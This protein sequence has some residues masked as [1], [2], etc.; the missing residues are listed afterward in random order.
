MILAGRVGT[1]T[2]LL[3]CIGCLA[4][5]ACSLQRAQTAQNAQSQLVGMSKEQ[6]LGCMGPPLQK[7]VEG[8]TEVWSYASGNDRTHVTYGDGV[9]VGTRR[10]CSVNVVMTTGR[11]S[12][13]NYS[14]PSGGLLSQGE[15]C[16]F[17]VQ[18]CVVR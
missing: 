2:K 8:Q 12:Q 10:S 3:I 11:V 5:A 17:A 9:A 13:V 15:Q 14:G 18:N 7:A 6:I 1:M 4:L 16:A